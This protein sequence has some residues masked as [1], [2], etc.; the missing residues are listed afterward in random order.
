MGTLPPVP[1][2]LKNSTKKQEKKWRH[3]F[4]FN[5]GA[6]H[7]DAGFGKYVEKILN[8]DIHDKMMNMI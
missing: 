2:K 5:D 7:K 4:S 8:L 6:L 1:M 3:S